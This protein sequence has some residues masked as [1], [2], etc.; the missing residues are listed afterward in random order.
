M[1]GDGNLARG[2]RLGILVFCLAIGAAFV[3]RVDLLAFATT[4]LTGLGGFLRA[5]LAFAI[6][7]GFFGLAATF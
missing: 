7:V 3:D 5:F 4:R 6:R 1:V 2:L